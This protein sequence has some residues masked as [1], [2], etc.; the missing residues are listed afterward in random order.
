[1]STGIYVISMERSKERRAYIQSHLKSLNLDFHIVEAIDGELV[2][3]DYL[4]SQADMERVKQSPYWLTKGAIA[5]ALS[6]K[7]AY[8]L[9]LDSSYDYALILEDDVV[10][11]PNINELLVSITDVLKQDEV[12]M[13]YYVSL[14]GAEISNYEGI[15]LKSGFLLN[16][17]D[18]KQICTTTAYVIGREV[19][20]KM[21]RTIIPVSVAADAWDYYYQK[22]CIKRLY[23][24]YPMETETKD[25]KSTIE[26][27]SEAS[28]MSRLSRVVDKYKIPPL[29]QIFRY[30]RKKFREKVTSQ[31][32]LTSEPSPYCEH[33][34]TISK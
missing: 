6:H 15:P 21:S 31:I 20:E 8:D 22:K 11:S 25:F 4:Y 28:L 1:M 16:P 7:K 24:H 9:F 17:M 19:A 2:D 10:L 27:F 18:L 29:Y 23:V 3:S 32:F 12:A 33:A 30:K 13:L 34:T 14:R 26:Y 5:C